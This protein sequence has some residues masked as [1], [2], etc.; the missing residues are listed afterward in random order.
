MATGFTSGMRN[1][2]VTILN[3]VQPSERQ[4]GEKT[5]YRRDGSLW[6]SYE[7]SKG[8]MALREGALDA[9]DSVMFRLNFSG[10]V[11]K[12]ITRESLIEM[13]GKIYQIQSLN[14][15]YHD[16]KIIIRATEMTTQVNIM[17]YRKIVTSQEHTVVTYDNNVVMALHEEV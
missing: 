10:N 8:T 5:G 4:F 13:H 1:H 9:Y 11:A 3:K 14:E 12:K 2:R 17:D 6:S 16:N 15:D 7:F